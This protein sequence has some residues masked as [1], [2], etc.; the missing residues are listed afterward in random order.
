MN[1]A[2][3]G[4]AFKELLVKNVGKHKLCLK[5]GNLIRK[6]VFIFIKNL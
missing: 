6:N 5:F 4:A 2:T 3:S 1:F